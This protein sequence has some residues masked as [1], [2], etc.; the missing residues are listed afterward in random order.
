MT[1]YKEFSRPE[2]AAA[3]INEI[4]P[5]GFSMT[6]KLNLGRPSWVKYWRETVPE[7]FDWV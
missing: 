5:F 6:F 2:E 7:Q 4:E 1:Q 3:F